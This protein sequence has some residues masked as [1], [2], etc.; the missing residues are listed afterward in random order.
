MRSGGEILQ[1]RANREDDIGGARQRIGSGRAGDAD[2]A[3]LQR[4]VP[5]QSAFASLRLGDRHAVRF[6]EGAQRVTGHAVEHA[7]AGDD[8]RTLG[9]AQER[10]RALELGGVRGRRAESDG[11][12]RKERFGIVPRHRLH[13]LRQRQRHRPAQCGIGEHVQR[14]RQ[15]REQLLGMD[16]AIEIA[17]H[18]PEAVVGRHGAVLEVLDLLQHRVGRAR[19]EYVAGQ[20]QHRQAVDM[21]QRRRGD[22]I[23]GA[24]TD[25]RGARHHAPAQVRLG[26]G[27]GSVGHRLFVV[28]T[29]GG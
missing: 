1:S 9:G 5:G 14:A 10:D 29:V 16:D 25:R 26:V 21:R 20:K 23:G 8:H 27:D 2:R 7:A 6:G 4:M 17:R 22:E 12:R 11:R 18:R 28:T 15:R 13:V 24:G 19:D 3:R